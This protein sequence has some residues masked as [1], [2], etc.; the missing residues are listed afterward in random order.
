MP[1]SP[2][3]H[4]GTGHLLLIRF[5]NLERTY[6]FPPPSYIGTSPVSP[7]EFLSCVFLRTLRAFPF[8]IPGT[9]LFTSTNS[10]LSLFLTSCCKCPGSA[11]LGL[12]SPTIMIFLCHSCLNPSFQTGQ[13]SSPGP[14]GVFLGLHVLADHRLQRSNIMSQNNP[15]LPL[16]PL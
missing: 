10:A 2:P 9:L 16:L 8:Y 13:S 7:C 1:I 6:P 11:L 5:T 3:S 14:F 12:V 4:P 15:S